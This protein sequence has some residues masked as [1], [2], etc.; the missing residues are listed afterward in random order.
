MAFALVLGGVATAGA[1][2]P[3]FHVEPGACP[4]ECCVYRTWT[5]R[6]ETPIHA[7]P[8]A[9]A[10]VVG[11]LK[12]GTTV[13]AITGEV[14]SRPVRFVVRRPHAGWAAGDS[15]WVYGYLGEGHFTVWRDGA[16]REEHLGFSPYG[17]TPGARCENAAQCWGELET[18][19]RFT[20]WVK[21]RTPDGR[22]GWSDRPERFDGKD[23]CG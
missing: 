12:A 14:H 18:P 22:E 6:A 15:L 23:A 13:Q 5:V 8:D 2:P 17:G 7:R 20:W 3:A 11:H 10:P 21:V 19:L 9:T 16:M 1:P 4:F